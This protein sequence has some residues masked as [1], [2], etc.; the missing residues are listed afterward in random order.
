M[1]C[2]FVLQYNL[3]DCDYHI[4]HYHQHDTDKCS[5]YL[6]HY[7]ELLDGDRIKKS[8]CDYYEKKNTS[9]KDTI[10]NDTIN[11]NLLENDINN[12]QNT[13]INNELEINQN[14][15]HDV[16]HY[17]LQ[18]SD[19]ELEIINKE[20]SVNNERA[21]ISSSMD[22]LLSTMIES[23][24]NTI[25]YSTIIYPDIDEIDE[26]EDID[27]DKEE[28]IEKIKKKVHINNEELVKALN[29]KYNGITTPIRTVTLDHFETVLKNNKENYNICYIKTNIKMLF[30]NP[31]NSTF[32]YNYLLCHEKYNKMV[33]KDIVNELKSLF[34]SINLHLIH[35]STVRY[36][37]S[38]D[39]SYSYIPQIV[40]E[41]NSLNYNNKAFYML[42]NGNVVNNSIDYDTIDYVNDEIQ[43]DNKN[44]ALLCCCTLIGENIKLLAQSPPVIFLDG[45]FM[46][47]GSTV[48]LV[49]TAVNINHESICLGF[50][51]FAS[52]SE[53]AWMSILTPLKKVLISLY[54]NKQFTF[55]SDQAKGIKSAVS[56]VFPNSPHILC[57]FHLLQDNLKVDPLTKKYIID[58]YKSST[59]EE[60]Q[61]KASKIEDDDLRKDVLDVWKKNYSTT[62]HYESICKW[63]IASSV[64]ES[65]NRVIKKNRNLP[66]HKMFLPLYNYE[67]VQGISAIVNDSVSYLVNLISMTCDCKEFQNRHTPCKHAIIYLQYL[68]NN[69]TLNTAILP[70]LLTN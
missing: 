35:Y 32:I 56:K 64:S 34:P 10:T 45:T 22:S 14:D 17:S 21:F 59:F 15:I 57:F 41:I 40:K 1:Q 19:K 39:L 42:Y 67:K 8:V 51:F 48:T 11:Q 18:L 46:G 7:I 13:N 38:Y 6:T 49:I 70:Q 43:V 30:K 27:I 26:E 65:Y 47:L 68:Q 69:G 61:D 25:D 62:Q 66:I 58:S 53:Q 12:N 52:E 31:L 33:L 55:I 60:A 36:L 44:N 54:G 50:E 2:N 3:K 4:S 5:K 29:D 63:Y 28:D 16:D 37:S 23:C 9:N 20:D 24:K